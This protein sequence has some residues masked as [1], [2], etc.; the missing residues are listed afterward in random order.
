VTRRTL[1]LTALLVAASVALEPVATAAELHIELDPD[2]TS[3]GFT[4]G[5][6]L[7]TVEGRVSLASG[8]LDLDR[9]SR[10][11]SG[12]IVVDATSADTGNDSRDE[13]MHTKVLMSGTHPMVVLRPERLAGEVAAQGTSTVELTGRM[14]LAGVSHEITIP[15]EVTVDGTGFSATAEFT[16]PYVAW[17]LEDPSKLLLRVA[18]EVEVT[19]ETHGAITRADPR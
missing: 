15:I 1:I 16:V 2:A 19:V 11:V 14:E 5:A 13:D 6:T 8:F 3:I 18:K 9:E 17:G 7:H 4:L 12:E 10:A